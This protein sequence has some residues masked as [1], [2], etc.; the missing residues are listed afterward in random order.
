[1]ETIK[2]EYAYIEHKMYLH[3]RYIRLFVVEINYVIQPVNYGGG[4]I[5][6]KYPDPVSDDIIFN[7]RTPYIGNW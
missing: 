6:L 5:S 7:Q 1:M 2:S 4:F 3:Q